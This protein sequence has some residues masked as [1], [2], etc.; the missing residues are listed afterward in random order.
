MSGIT[1]YSE[2]EGRP[3]KSGGGES[4]G[5][6]VR[7]PKLPLGKRV[8]QFYHDVKTELKNTTWPTRSHVWSTTIIVVIAVIFFGFYLWGC[9]R[10][11]TLFFNYLEKAMK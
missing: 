6:S 2:E 10:L 11:F 9:D 1:E 8:G 5:I 3:G 4:A 7:L